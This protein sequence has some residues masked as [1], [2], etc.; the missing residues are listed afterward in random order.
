MWAP[1]LFSDE[2]KQKNLDGVVTCDESAANKCR[3]GVFVKEKRNYFRSLCLRKTSNAEY[4]AN[5]IKIKLIPKI[6]LKVCVCSSS[7]SLDSKF[8]RI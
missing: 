4:C 6:A 8:Y 3:K 2:Q 7:S 1:R 5:V